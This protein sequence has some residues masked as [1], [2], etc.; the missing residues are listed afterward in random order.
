VIIEEGKLMYKQSQQLIDTS[1]GLKSDKWIFVLSTSKS[2]YVGKVRSQFLFFLVCFKIL[3][4]VNYIVVFEN[5]FVPRKLKNARINW[6][7]KSITFC[8]FQISIE[9]RGTWIILHSKQSSN[10]Y[11]TLFPW[12]FS[13]VCMSF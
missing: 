2:L 4:T 8:P 13:A 7:R 1:E 10:D 12:G 5:K 3:K 11:S 9:S 6:L